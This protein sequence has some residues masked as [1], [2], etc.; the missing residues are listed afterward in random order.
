MMEPV[1]QRRNFLKLA[2]AAA[3]VS[4]KAS[5]AIA[6]SDEQLRQAAAAPIFKPE[7]LGSP[8]V[9]DSIRLLRK[10]RNYFIHVRSKDGA[11]GISLDNGRATDFYPILHEL[12]VPYF[13]GKD[14]RDLETH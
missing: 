5:A 3:A 12:I 6:P 13:V 4:V 8:I 9:I 2:A 11:E 1:M 7:G 14:V 10:D